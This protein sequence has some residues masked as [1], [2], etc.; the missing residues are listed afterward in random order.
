MILKL[1]FLNIKNTRIVTENI[2]SLFLEY[3]LLVNIFISVIGVLD[4]S[5]EIIKTF[6]NL[7]GGDSTELASLFNFMKCIDAFHT[8]EKLR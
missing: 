3:N 5:T 6:G 4:S 2:V 8:V 7:I 1:L